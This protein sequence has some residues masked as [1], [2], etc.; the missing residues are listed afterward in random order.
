MIATV[1]KWADRLLSVVVPKTEAGACPCGDIYCGLCCIG[2][3]GNCVRYRYQVSCD[4]S[5][6]VRTCN[7]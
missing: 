7:C 5:T 4:C 2:A 3:P 6:N 1:G